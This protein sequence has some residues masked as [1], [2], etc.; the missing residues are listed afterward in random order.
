MQAVGWTREDELDLRVRAFLAERRS[1][2]ESRNFQKADAIR[3]GLIEAGIVL[4][5]R[6][7]GE[8]AWER[9]PDFDPMKLVRLTA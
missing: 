8:T 1:A 4:M 7:D 3:D 2:R 6:P 9:G 5:D